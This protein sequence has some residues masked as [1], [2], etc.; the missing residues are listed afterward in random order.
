ML[1]IPASAPT[2]GIW[3]KKPWVGEVNCDT[4]TTLVGTNLKLKLKLQIIT[5][6]G[7]IG[8]RIVGQENSTKAQS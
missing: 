4:H 6:F 3:K 1:R 7:P 5:K 2:W 8:F